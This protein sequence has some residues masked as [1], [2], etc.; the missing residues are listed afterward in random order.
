[1]SHHIPM[2]GNR[3]CSSGAFASRGIRCNDVAAV[4]RSITAEMSEGNAVDRSTI[5]GFSAG[6]AS[7]PGTSLDT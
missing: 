2:C 6:R 5:A 7:E 3:S 4:D 1:M